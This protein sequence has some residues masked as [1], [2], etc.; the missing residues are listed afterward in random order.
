MGNK[1]IYKILAILLVISVIIPLSAWPQN[2]EWQERPILLGTSGS[3][4]NDISKPR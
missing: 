1:N 4:I 2:D 3:N